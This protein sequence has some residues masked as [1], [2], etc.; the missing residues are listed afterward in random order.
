MSTPIPLSTLPPPIPPPSTAKFKALV[1]L[2]TAALPLAFPSGTTLDLI[3][4]AVDEVTTI[5]LELDTMRR[6][7]AAI[8][9]VVGAP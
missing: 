4:D 9:A 8:A 5:V 1:D 3:H 7:L 2:A 6:K